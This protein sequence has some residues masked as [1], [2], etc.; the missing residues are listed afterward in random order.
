[1]EDHHIAVAGA[2]I[3]QHGGVAGLPGV[4]K[5]PLR[6]GGGAV[7][8]VVRGSV[9]GGALI[10]GRRILQRGAG[11]IGGVDGVGSGLGGGHGLRLHLLGH[12]DLIA[13]LVAGGSGPVD[14]DILAVHHVIG[15]EVGLIGGL[16]LVAGVGQ[17]VPIVLEVGGGQ[18]AAAGLLL[19]DALGHG[20]AVDQAQVLL[21][22]VAVGAG[23][24]G[25]G[26]Q[27]RVQLRLHIVVPGEAVGLGGVA[28]GMDAGELLQRPVGEVV[29]PGLALLSVGDE[30]HGGGGD[31]LVLQGGVGV[32]AD[33]AE[34]AVVVVEEVLVVVLEIVIHLSGGVLLAVDGGGS[35]RLGDDIG[36]PDDGDD[37]DHQKHHADG[38]VQEIGAARLFAL[39]GLLGG[40]GIGPA[41]AHLLLPGLL[42]S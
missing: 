1:M 33:H 15:G 42:F 22:R 24:G 41:G 27:R 2:L 6:Q 19:V 32:Q 9:G 36:S 28:H 13:L 40:L 39:L 3:L 16:Q 14:P 30:H 34:E 23:G 8:E 35:G 29:V 31:G 21:L 18:Q 25:Q 20:A 12:L 4:V 7:R 37:R 26:L 38:A 17:A 10:L 11:L 5:H